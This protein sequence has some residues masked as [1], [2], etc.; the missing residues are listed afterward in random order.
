MKSWPHLRQKRGGH[1]R[2]QVSSPLYGTAVPCAGATADYSPF[3]RAE[4]RSPLRGGGVRLGAADGGGAD[5]DRPTLASPRPAAFS[6]GRLAR[7][8][9]TGAEMREPTRWCWSP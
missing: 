7:A 3:A 6:G 2:G 8:L 5:T 1:E 4:L 9:V